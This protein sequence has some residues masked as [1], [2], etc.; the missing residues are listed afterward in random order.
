MRHADVAVLCFEEDATE[1]QHRFADIDLDMLK[2][3]QEM[4]RDG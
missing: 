3:S 1:D 4:V 2:S